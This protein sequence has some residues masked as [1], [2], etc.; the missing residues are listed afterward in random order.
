MFRVLVRAL[1]EGG[2]IQLLG[3]NLLVEHADAVTLLLSAATTFRQ[4]TRPAHVAT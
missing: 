1:P 3:D 2:V 4:T